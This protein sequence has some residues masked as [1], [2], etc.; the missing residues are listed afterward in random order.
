[1]TGAGDSP[2]TPRDPRRKT[3]SDSSARAWWDWH[4]FGLWIL[5]NG[6]AFIVLPLAGTALEQ[7]A[8]LATKDSQPQ[9]LHFR[10]IGRWL[11]SAWPQTQS[12]MALVLSQ[13]MSLSNLAIS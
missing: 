7:L 12:I 4:L 10:L 11:F 6:L 1:M 8:S 3:G 13:P 2:A 5:V 9:R